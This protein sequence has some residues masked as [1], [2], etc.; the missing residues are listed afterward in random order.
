MRRTSMLAL[1]FM[2]SFRLC[3]SKAS[4]QLLSSLPSPQTVGT[5][6]ALDAK[7]TLDGD[8]DK[9]R[10]LVQFRFTVSVDGGPFRILSDFNGG[11]GFVWRPD[12][13]EH[14]ARVKVTRRN[15]SRKK[16]WEG[17]LPF[18]TLPR[19]NAGKPV[20]SPTA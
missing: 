20:V 16:T 18:R 17:D 5:A 6:I 9:Q 8:P 4:V 7:P 13:Y 11:T 14:E 10:R 2:L 15:P 19:A 1:M 12:L 3:W